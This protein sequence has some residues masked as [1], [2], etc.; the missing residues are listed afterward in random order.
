M[1]WRLTVVC[2]FI[3]AAL[4]GWNKYSTQA[5]FEWRL[6]HGRQYKL[7]SQAGR[8]ERYGDWPLNFLMWVSGALII[9]SAMLWDWGFFIA[10]S[11]MQNADEFDGLA[12]IIIIALITALVMRGIY[13]AAQQ[14]RLLCLPHQVQRRMHVLKACHA[15]VVAR[16]V[17][18]QRELAPLYAKMRER[19]AAD[20]EAGRR[21]VKS[22]IF[23]SED[24][25][26]IDSRTEEEL[27]FLQT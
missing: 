8:F 23:G 24:I 15:V 5:A 10:I 12:N 7:V 2:S 6:R 3:G 14:V 11:G 26:I 27:S 17:E 21:P 18:F 19:A 13:A 20:R 22:E 4:L 1:V 25:E 9:V 16:E